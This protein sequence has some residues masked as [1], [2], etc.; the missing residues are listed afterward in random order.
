MRSIPATITLTCLLFLFGCG[1][2]LTFSVDGPAALAIAARSKAASRM[3]RS[4]FRHPEKMAE[5]CFLTW[6]GRRYR[7]SVEYTDVACGCAGRPAS[8][9]VFI[10]PESG[11]V[12]SLQTEGGSNKQPDDACAARCH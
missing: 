5:R 2:A 7:W 11:R 9:K 1:D 4:R 3:V 6:D 12:L 10:D 8:V